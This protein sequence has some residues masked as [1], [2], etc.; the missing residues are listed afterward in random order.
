[1][2]DPKQVIGKNGGPRRRRGTRGHWPP[3]KKN[4]KRV[5]YWFWLKN[6]LGYIWAI[7]SQTHRGSMLWSQSSGIFANFRRKKLSFFSKTTNYFRFTSLVG[8]N[9]NYDVIA[10]YDIPAHALRQV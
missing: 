2:V 4:K 1:V 8:L 6:G 7:S 10:H 3:P 9:Y 5:M